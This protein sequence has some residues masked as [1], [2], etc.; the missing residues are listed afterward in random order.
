MPVDLK[1]FNFYFLTIFGSNLLCN[2]PIIMMLNKNII[3]KSK[4][5]RNIKRLTFCLTLDS[6]D[7]P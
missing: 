7:S 1:I 3:I 2:L 6:V 5:Y 4:D